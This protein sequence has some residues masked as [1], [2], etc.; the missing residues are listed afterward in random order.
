MPR[1]CLIA[2][3]DPWLLQLLRVFTEESGFRVVQVHEAQDVLPTI[4]REEPAAILLQVD[5]PGRVMGRELLHMLN[6]N[7]CASHI[8]VLAFSWQNINISELPD[9]VTALLQEPVTYDA[10]VD[11][12]A[13]AGITC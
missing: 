12:L 13:K 3:Y 8:P 6:Q 10:F 7:P 1:T 11:A 2:A 9:G 5:L 4:E